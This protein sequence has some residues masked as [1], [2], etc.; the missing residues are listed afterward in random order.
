MSTLNSLFIQKFLDLVQKIKPNSAVELVTLH[1]S[2]PSLMSDLEKFMEYNQ[3]IQTKILF[4]KKIHTQVFN[5]RQ[6]EFDAFNF[7]SLKE[8]N[9]ERLAGIKKFIDSETYRAMRAFLETT[10]DFFDISPLNSDSLN[11][12]DA[13]FKDKILVF[14]SILKDLYSKVNIDS[15]VIDTLILII[16]RI[17]NR[18][19]E[20]NCLSFYNTAAYEQYSNKKIGERNLDEQ[21]NEVKNIND[22]IAIN[23]IWI[24]EKIIAYFDAE[25][26]SYGFNLLE[27][28]IKSSN[29]L[30]MNSFTDLYK[31]LS[32]NQ[33]AD[34]ELEEELDTEEELDIEEE[35]DTEGELYVERKL[36]IEK[37]LNLYI[38]DIMVLLI[39]THSED[40]KKL[41]LDTHLDKKKILCSLNTY[42]LLHSILYIST[43][44]IKDNLIC[45]TDYIKIFLANHVSIEECLPKINDPDLLSNK[46]AAITKAVKNMVLFIL[47]ITDYHVIC[48]VGPES[49]YENCQLEIES[50][51]S[52]T[53]SLTFSD[54][55]ASSTYTSP[56]L[57][58]LMSN[59]S[60][61]NSLFNLDD[62]DYN[63]H[64]PEHGLGLGLEQ[65]KKPRLVGF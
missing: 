52:A 54:S 33:A 12:F 16:E 14:P 10:N 4:L 20:I 39:A 28:G 62:L 37:K 9:P 60:S 53:P 23:S 34:E 55:P 49:F 50:I 29:T 7:T 27:P 64:G 25:H 48:D 65:D 2:L 18:V 32:S 35:L 13:D 58:P 24:V 30:N 40:I 1:N 38:N 59:N 43:M 5:I 46:V 61:F 17:A 47:N 6:E 26:D 44:L 11:K 45:E 41:S 56:H 51:M 15:G 19:S 63:A 3:L 22:A 42:L 31:H 21:N 36:A 57:C 8:Q